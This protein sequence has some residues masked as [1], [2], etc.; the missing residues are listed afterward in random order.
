MRGVGRRKNAKCVGYVHGCLS[1]WDG[2]SYMKS[3]DFFATHRRRMHV[4]RVR[5]IPARVDNS[6]FQCSF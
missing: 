3:E 4:D 5:Q 1:V 6:E 2:N